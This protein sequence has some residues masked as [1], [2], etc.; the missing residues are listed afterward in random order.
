MTAQVSGRVGAELSAHVSSALETH[1]D[2]LRSHLGEQLCFLVQTNARLAEELGVVQ[3]A[4]AEHARTAGE[5]ATE[6]KVS[7]ALTQQQLASLGAE[8]AQWQRLHAAEAARVR[9][10]EAELQAARAALS[11]QQTAP[12]QLGATFPASS[13]PRDAGGASGGG[14]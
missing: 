5:Q 2:Q 10:L 11:P 7:L 1:G 4:A 8:C 6:L 3:R 13:S 12:P 9:Q 14:R